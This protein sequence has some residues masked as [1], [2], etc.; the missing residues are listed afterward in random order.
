MADKKTGSAHFN[1]ET[2][3]YDQY[4]ADS[5]KHK[6]EKSHYTNMLSF[7]DVYLLAISCAIRDNMKPV[8]SK[9]THWFLRTTSIKGLDLTILQSLIYSY[10]NDLKILLPRKEKEFQDIAEKLANAGWESAME[11]LKT[12]SEWEREVLILKNKVLK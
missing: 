8:D 5:E 1:I 4:Q 2:K 10:A 12:P 7:K 11:I 3:Y 6:E 9:K